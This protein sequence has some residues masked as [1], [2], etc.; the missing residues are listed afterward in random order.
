MKIECE[1]TVN[2][3]TGDFVTVTLNGD[4]E[5]IVELLRKLNFDLDMAKELE[6]E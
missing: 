6:V 5:A 2:K 4:F 3:I 1:V